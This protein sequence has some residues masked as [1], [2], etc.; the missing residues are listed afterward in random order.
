MNYYALDNKLYVVIKAFF[1]VEE[2][3]PIVKP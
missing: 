1:E 3:F 2:Y